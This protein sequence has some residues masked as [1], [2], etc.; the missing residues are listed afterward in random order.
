LTPISDKRRPRDLPLSPPR[1]LTGNRTAKS[2]LQPSDH[3]D[4]VKTRSRPESYGPFEAVV[5]PPRLQAR[6][7]PVPLRGTDRRH[8]LQFI[9]PHR[10]TKPSRR[11][12]MHD[13]A[14]N[15]ICE[16]TPRMPCKRKRRFQPTEMFRA[17][18]M[19]D[20]G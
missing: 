9:S 3:F 1:L 17:L 20:Q 14:Q 10:G 18:F 16:D 15:L 6:T 13:G 2:H 7:C 19:H 12:T 5:P 11:C 8:H 4:A